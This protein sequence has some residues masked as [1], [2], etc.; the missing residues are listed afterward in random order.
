MPPSL[1]RLDSNGARRLGRGCQGSGGGGGTH[2]VFSGGDATQVLHQ[3][4]GASGVAAG[5]RVLPLPWEG[6]SW[7]IIST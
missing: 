4:W 6:R 5:P 2:V 1:A 3:F 7:E